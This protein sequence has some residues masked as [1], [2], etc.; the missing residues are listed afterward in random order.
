ML[1]SQ[2]SEELEIKFE[3]LRREETYAVPTVCVESRSGY[4]AFG[5]FAKHSKKGRRV[6]AFGA[7][8][9]A[10]IYFYF[11]LYIFARG[12]THTAGSAYV[13]AL[14]RASNLIA[15]TSES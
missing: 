6:G 3:C 7:N 5:S 8:A 14:R 4:Q 13:S 12:F 15:S 2:L 1:I 10:Y 11:N 9:T